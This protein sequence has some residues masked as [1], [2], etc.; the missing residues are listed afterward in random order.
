ME[1]KSG[2]G[3]FVLKT[4]VEE[5][6]LQHIRDTKTPEEAWDIFIYHAFLKQ[7]HKASNF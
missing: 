1:D 6:V 3:N 7:G 2:Q 4:M 5:N